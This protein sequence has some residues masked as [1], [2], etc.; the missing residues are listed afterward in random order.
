MDEPKKFVEDSNASLSKLLEEWAKLRAR[1]KK[2]PKGCVK[3]PQ[4]GW[5]KF[6]CTAVW[7]LA[8]P[9]TLPLFTIIASIGVYLGWSCLFN[10]CAI[11][12]LLMI[13]RSLYITSCNNQLKLDL[14]LL[15]HGLSE[16]IGYEH[17]KEIEKRHK[18]LIR[19][20]GKCSVEMDR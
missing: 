5:Q 6:H 15:I 18:Q 2:L 3:K 10:A 20:D 14:L 17:D 11:L 13:N 8:Q 7:S 1:L 16:E 9:M 19:E 12:L 4:S